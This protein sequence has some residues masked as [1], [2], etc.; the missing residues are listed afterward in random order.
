MQATGGKEKKKKKSTDTYMIPPTNQST[1]HTLQIYWSIF[2]FSH[3]F[4]SITV[5]FASFNKYFRYSKYTNEEL[6]VCMWKNL[7][8][9]QYWNGSNLNTLYSVNKIV[10]ILLDF[11]WGNAEAWEDGYWLKE[12]PIFQLPFPYLFPYALPPTS[13]MTAAV[14]Q[15][16][17]Y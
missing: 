12:I 15:T 5:F 3:C 17:P 13:C 14:G 16:A 1:T 9:W 11:T 10:K 6:I 4:S 7:Y 8:I 2:P